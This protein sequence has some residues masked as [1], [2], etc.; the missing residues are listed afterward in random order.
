MP[1]ELAA[2]TVP[3]FLNAGLS[4]ATESI[5]VPARGY[6]SFANVEPSGRVTGTSSSVK[7]HSF[8][9]FSARR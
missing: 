9:A 1:L 3:S 8:S 4:F 2:V 5:V 7:T 6:S